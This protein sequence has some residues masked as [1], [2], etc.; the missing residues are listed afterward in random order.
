MCE[1]EKR[2]F[3]PEEGKEFL[4]GFRAVRPGAV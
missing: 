3:F 2:R 1:G 4:C